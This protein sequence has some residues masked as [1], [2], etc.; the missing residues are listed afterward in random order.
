MRLSDEEL[1]NMSFIVCVT[2]FK[3]VA[4]EESEKPKQ[5]DGRKCVGVAVLGDH[6]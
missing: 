4:D 2:F 6:N 1:Q 3:H 5:A